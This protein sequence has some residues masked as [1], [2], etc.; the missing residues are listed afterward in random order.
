MAA[1]NSVF[2]VDQR[3]SDCDRAK[4]EVP[5]APVSEVLGS[6]SVRAEPEEVK[7]NVQERLI[8]EKL[9]LKILVKCFVFTTVLIIAPVVLINNII[10]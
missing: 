8:F 5:S 1:S 6:S 10:R 9:I 4:A 2:C 3:H 7:V